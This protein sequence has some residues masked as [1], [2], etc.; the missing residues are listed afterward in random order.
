MLKTLRKTRSPRQLVK[1]FA[2]TVAGLLVFT[3]LAVPTVLALN[4]WWY[5][6][7]HAAEFTARSDRILAIYKSL[8]LPSDYDLR[9]DHV[10][11]DKRVYDWDPS[12][13]YSSSR[14]YLRYANV[15]AT[16]AELR[17]RIEAAGFAFFEEP[18]PNAVIKEYHFKSAKGE[19]IRLNVSS[20]T[21]DNDMRLHGVNSSIDPNQGP[22]TVTIKVNL[23]DNNE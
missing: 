21:R 7:Q 16:V 6:H 4:H 13:T 14:V 22:S 18:Y 8:Q 19:Y 12:R 9:S 17:P 15:D 10:F 23:D 11:G 1:A 5:L 3:A 20:Q 2:I